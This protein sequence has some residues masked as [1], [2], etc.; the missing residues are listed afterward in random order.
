M[1]TSKCASIAGH[2]DGRVEALKQYMRHCPMENVQGYIGSHWLLPLGNYSFRIA[3]V[4]ARVTGETMTM[5]K[6]TLFAGHFNGHG[7][8]LVQ[9]QAHCTIKEVR[10]FD[11]CHWSL[12]PGQYCGQ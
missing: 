7:D 1:T 9:Y 10:G 12:P 2:F 11:K 5:G 3:P 8:V 4:D 6:Y